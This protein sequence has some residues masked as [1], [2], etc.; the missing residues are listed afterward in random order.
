VVC[1]RQAGWEGVRRKRK[2]L[3]RP[4]ADARR[5]EGVRC[6][7]TKRA[8]FRKPC[9]TPPRDMRG[10]LPRDYTMAVP[11]IA[12]IYIYIYTLYTLNTCI[13]IYMI[14]IVRVCILYI[15]YLRIHIIIYSI[16]RHV[17]KYTCTRWRIITATASSALGLL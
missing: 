2:N 16:Y 14:Y 3:L 15:I 10:A 9:G 5:G 4:G 1:G 13:G 12:H 17:R 8:S 6:Q 11:R 7:K